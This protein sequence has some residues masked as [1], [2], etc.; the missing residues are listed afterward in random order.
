MVDLELLHN[1]TTS[2]CYTL[3]SKP[4]LK[5]LWQIVIPQLAF[6]QD[7]L[8]RGL[9]AVSAL[10]LAHFAPQEKRGRYAAQAAM[11]QDRALTAVRSAMSN[12]TRENCD[13]L[14]VFST[15]VIIF[16][17]AQPRVPDTLLFIGSQDQGMAEWLLLIRGV[18]TII[19]SA[20]DWIAAGPVSPMLKSGGDRSSSEYLEPPESDRLMD[21]SQLIKE[22]TVDEA[23]LEAYEDAIRKLRKCFSAVCASDTRICH[24][25]PAFSWPIRIS[26]EY[27]GLLRKHTPEALAIFAHYSVL[28]KKLDGFWWV[29]GWGTSLLST[30]YGLLGTEYR[31]WIRWPIQECGWIPPRRND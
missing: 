25:A 23:E 22:T 12:V 6:S 30:I 1:F 3:S 8:M 5:S 27:M 9:L 16:T 20:R 13:A 7:F 21:L 14:F 4:D 28:L 31:L 18:H 11:Q 10:H 29:Q 19:R 26:D 17:F 24:L 15:S 2:T